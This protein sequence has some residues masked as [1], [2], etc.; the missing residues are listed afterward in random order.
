MIQLTD[1]IIAFDLPKNSS[2]HQVIQGYLWFCKSNIS[3]T[4]EIKLPPGDWEIIG[5]ADTVTEEVAS[6]IVFQVVITDGPTR[7]MNYSKEYNEWADM[8]TSALESFRSLMQSKGLVYWNTVGER[9][10]VVEHG[11]SFTHYNGDMDAWQAAEDA[12]KNPLILRR[13]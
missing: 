3:D 13:K 9:P 12:R 8:F 6:S 2:N 5:T 1:K 4:D 10:E 11:M 7:F